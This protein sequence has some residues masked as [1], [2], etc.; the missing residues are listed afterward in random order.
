MQNPEAP[1]Q[2][3]FI[4]VNIPSKYMPLVMYGF[5]CLFS[6]LQ[7]DF[8]IAIVIGYLYSQ[9]YFAKAMPSSEFLTS[10]EG[11]NVSANRLDGGS[12]SESGLQGCLS[13]IVRPAQQWSG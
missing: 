8:F 10:L 12:G 5:F 6:G 13:R 1:R 3:M 2:M 7:L 4:P 9:D 11:P